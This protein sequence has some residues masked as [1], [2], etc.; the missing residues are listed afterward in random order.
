MSPSRTFRNIFVMLRSE[1]KTG[2]NDVLV[3][4]L[5]EVFRDSKVLDYVKN[6]VLEEVGKYRDSMS[7]ASSSQLAAVASSLS[8]CVVKQ[9]GQTYEQA[10]AVASSMCNLA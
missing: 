8:A 4:L 1:V 10:H 5:R 9:F 6:L 7:A 3:E 2:I